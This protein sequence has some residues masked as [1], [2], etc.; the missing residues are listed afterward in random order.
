MT[1]AVSVKDIKKQQDAL[2]KDYTVAQGAMQDALGKL[3]EK[4]TALVDFNNK[5][6]RVIKL[7]EED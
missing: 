6:G 3:A 2:Q 7:M 5:Y 4:K 1:K